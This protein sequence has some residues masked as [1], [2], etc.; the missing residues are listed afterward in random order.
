MSTNDCPGA[1]AGNN[2][3]LAMG[4]WAEAADG[5]LIFVQSTEGNRVIFSVFDMTRKTEYRSAMPEPAFKDNFT[6]KGG[7]GGSKDRWTWHDKT[8][9]P[10]DRLIKAGFDEGERPISATDQLNAAQRVAESLKAMGADVK[11]TQ[12]GDFSHRVE[13]DPGKAAANRIL[14][15]IGRAVNELLR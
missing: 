1:V 8:A 14:D 9:F 6:W 10:W 3:E 12:G 7:K 13:S 15:K 11:E 4:C 2:D 5:S